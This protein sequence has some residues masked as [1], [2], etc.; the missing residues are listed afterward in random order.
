M[1][2]LKSL[3]ELK[4]HLQEKINNV[5]LN[6]TGEYIK[7]ME[8]TLIDSL[9]Y[10]SYEPTKYKRR[11]ENGGLKDPNNIE[12]RLDADGILVVSNNTPFSQEPITANQGNEL[13]GLIEYGSG[14]YKDYA[15]EYISKSGDSPYT[16]PRPVI[17][18]TA[19]FVRENLA[20]DIQIGLRRIGLNVKKT[21]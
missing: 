2:E 9:V 11:E 16:Y 8:L 21:K 12:V 18:E 20:D 4:K 6:Q 15:Y 13:I 17:S 19:E 10:D 7:E 14:G 1:P 5:L 3:G